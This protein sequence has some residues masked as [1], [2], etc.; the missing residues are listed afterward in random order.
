MRLK[1]RIVYAILILIP[2][3]VFP[4]TNYF[5]LRFEEPRR[6][7]VA[8]EMFLSGDYIVPKI[9]GA[10]YYN[11]PPLFNWM[12]LALYKLF[13]RTD[14]WMVRLPSLL[15][16]LGMGLLNYFFV[17]KW[18]TKEVALLSSIFF[19][20]AGDIYFYETMESGEIDL[21]YSFLVCVQVVSIYH[22][23]QKKNWLAL[24]GVSYAFMAFGLLTKGMPS[25]L[26]QALTLAAMAV[27]TKQW[28]WLLKWQ[29]F[30]GV[31]L[32]LGL[33]GGYY[34][35]Y[36]QR[37]DLP[38]F[39]MKL[40]NEASEKSTLESK[41]KDV[42]L[43]PINYPLELAK[44]LLPWSLFSVFIFGKGFRSTL[45]TYPLLRFILLFVL[46]NLPIY[47]FTG[48]PKSRYVFMFFP[49]FTTL[50]AAF[51]LQNM[52]IRPLLTKI[53]ERV[54][55]GL[56]VLMSV[57][58]LVAPFLKV[59]DVVPAAFLKGIGM[60]L[61]LLATLALYLKN[62]SLR[63]YVIVLFIVLGKTAF[64]FFYFPIYKS[65][66]TD[67]LY[68][69]NLAKITRITGN[70]PVFYFNKVDTVNA[71]IGIGPVRLDSTQLH[72]PPFMSYEVPYYYSKF[73]NNI[74]RFTDHLEPGNYYITLSDAPINKPFKL[75]YSF[76]DEP[77]SKDILLIQTGHPE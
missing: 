20:T 35:A 3:S 25:F 60:G 29:H 14:E 45:K 17:K 34:Y 67:M 69:D 21:F 51:S 26:F 54:F 19:L 1:S 15:A 52:P 28:K 38:A 36:A 68:K 46:F 58:F 6:G 13:N 27:Y 75:I 2:L 30:A 23:W 12:I 73:T 66:S 10:F 9:H 7:I 53:I 74:L 31:L 50:L 63:I 24:F 32:G 71:K 33:A 61:L 76:R 49:F 18:L 42:A 65:Q 47:F 64:N 62:P 39:L 72:L 4:W 55:I 41:W 59:S 5:D 77:E 57:A 43:T 70:E 37:A 44:W 48:Y 8:L 11:K 22:F 40:F 56:M 16:W